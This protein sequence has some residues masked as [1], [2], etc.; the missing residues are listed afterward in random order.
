MKVKHAI[1]IL[2]LG[3]CLDFIAAL[4]KILHYSCA[5]Y[6]F[7]MSTFFKVFGGLLFIYK[8]LTH[9]KVKDFMNY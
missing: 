6:L 2:I 9:P 3:Y 1:V 5:D 7:I 4:F 8:I